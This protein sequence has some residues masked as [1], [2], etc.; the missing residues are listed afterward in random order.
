[1]VMGTLWLFALSGCGSLSTG[2]TLGLVSED[3]A[4][5]PELT[6]ERDWAW[7]SRWGAFTVFECGDHRGIASPPPSRFSTVLPLTNASLYDAD[8]AHVATT[9]PAQTYCLAVVGRTWCEDSLRYVGDLAA[10]D[11]CWPERVRDGRSSPP[12]GLAVR[13][14]VRGQAVVD[15]H[16]VFPDG[17]QSFRITERALGTYPE[18]DARTPDPYSVKLEDQGLSSVELEKYLPFR[19][20]GHVGVYAPWGDGLSLYDEGTGDLAARIWTGSPPYMT[21]LGDPEIF[22]RCLFECW[23]TGA[24]PDATCLSEPRTFE[25]IPPWMVVRT[26]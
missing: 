17:Q 19:C 9:R 8:G 13:R 22:G 16:R 3:R 20:T 14:F 24:E 2:A 4:P 25:G 7:R 23:T 6:Y 21:L 26:D 12:P 5:H 11:G 1:M 15:L 18:A 10:L